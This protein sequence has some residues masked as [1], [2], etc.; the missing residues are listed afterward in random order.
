MAKAP[1]P[2]RVKTR[3]TPH[4]DARS[5][6]ALYACLLED[7][8]ARARAVAGIRVVV[9]CPAEDVEA[10]AAL[11]PGVAVTAQQGSGLS[12]GLRWVFAHFCARGGDRV[13]A[14]DSDSPHLPPAAV[15]SAFASLRT[16][17]LV[18]GPTTDGGYYLVGA[19]AAHPALFG[20]DGLGTGSA[21]DS[22]QDGARQ[23]G[24]ATALLEECYDIDVPGDVERLQ[25][26]LGKWPERAPR[27]ARLLREWRTAPIPS[28]P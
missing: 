26:D 22:L 8:L 17:D 3:L 2:G 4:Y 5:V 27:T 13:V 12:D 15:E 23:L 21:L 10:L 11:L 19:K 1:R 14:L 7:T 18:I 24:L 20:P 9:V 6:A 16:N 25:A 28:T